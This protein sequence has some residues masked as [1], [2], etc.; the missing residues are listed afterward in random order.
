[1]KMHA[2]TTIP[3]ASLPDRFARG[4]HCL[5]L[6]DDYG[7][8]P[9]SLSYF[10]GQ[11]VVFRGEDHKAHILDAY[12]IHMGAD[13]ARGTVEGDGI[14]CPFHGWRW[15]VDGVCDDIP[16]A[17]KIP[18]K[19]KMRVWP[20]REENGLLFVWHDAEYNG[21]IAEQAPPRMEACFSEQWSPWSIE[22]MTINTNCRELVDN[23]ADVA[24]FVPVHANSI[25]SFKNISDRHIFMQAQTGG[26]ETLSD[27]HL[28]STA[29]YYGPAYMITA[30]KGD[31]DG[32]SVESRLLVSHVPVT[33]ESFDLRFGVMVKKVP[34]LSEAENRKM[35]DGYVELTRA[36]FFQDVD[37]WHNKVKVDSPVLCDGDGPIHK[38]RYWYDQFYVDIDSVPASLSQKKEYAVNV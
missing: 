3:K 7:R 17:K 1:M 35:V 15:G 29:T 32:N 20:T 14:R 9:Q 5:G 27:D 33:Q 18:A 25:D 6:A 13:L 16:Y 34:E 23:M 28:I 38:L 12:C 37:I 26:S 22:I 19:A 31:V 10:G 2:F 36:A 8:Q 4:W 11:L 21:P 24:H 30:M